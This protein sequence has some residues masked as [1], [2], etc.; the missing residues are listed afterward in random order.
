MIYR[1]FVAIARGRTADDGG[2]TNPPRS[3]PV[4]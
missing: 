4:A 2:Q 3:A 1:N